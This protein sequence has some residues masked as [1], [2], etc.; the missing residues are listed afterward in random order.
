IGAAQRRLRDARIAADDHQ[1]GEPPGAEI[2]AA[3]LTCERLE[4]RALREAQMEADPV[5]ERAEVDMAVARR[6]TFCLTAGAVYLTSGNVQFGHV[7]RL[8]KRYPPLAFPPVPRQY[9]RGLGMPNSLIS[10][11][12]GPEL[13]A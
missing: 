13:S 9:T 12:C 2:D 6:S 4:R 5:F 7:W 11:C 8:P 10:N 1:R 3:R